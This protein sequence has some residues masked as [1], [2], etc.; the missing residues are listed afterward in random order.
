VTG[1]GRGV[2]GGG[3]GVAGGGREVVVGGLPNCPHIRTSY[4]EDLHNLGERRVHIGV[5]AEAVGA[6]A[7]HVLV[8]VETHVWEGGLYSSDVYTGEVFIEKSVTVH[9]VCLPHCLHHLAVRSGVAQDLVV[10]EDDCFLHLQLQ[11]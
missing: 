7:S 2:T 3:R 9:P 1:G 8:C 5:Q 11:G 4:T 10:I 6:E